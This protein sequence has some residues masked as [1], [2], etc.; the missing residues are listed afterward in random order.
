ML[1]T[2]VSDPPGSDGWVYEVKWDGYRA[3]AY[4]NKTNV[5]IRSRNNLEFNKKFYPIRDALKEVS[6]QAILDGEIIVLDEEGRSHFESLQNWRSE[7]DGQ[8]IYYVFDLLWANGHSLMH[9]P[10]TERREQLQSIF[11]DHPL[12]R[13]SEL[14]DTNGNEFLEVAKKM[15]MEGIMAKRTD[16]EYTPSARTKEWLKIKTGLRQEVVIGGFT[17]N[18]GTSKIF[19]ALLVGV[20]EKGK[21]RYTGK[22]G[23]GFSIRLQQEMMKQFKP[24]ISKENPFDT[25]PDINKPSRFRPDP[26]DAKATWLKPKL[27]CEVSFTEMTRDGMMRHPSFE[28]MREDK[29]AMQGKEE[30]PSKIKTEKKSPELNG[31]KI[32]KKAAAGGRKT[33]V[34][35][36]DKQQVR[37]VDGRELKFT[38]LDKIYWPKEKITKGDMINYY[39]K[40]AP[41]MLPYMKDRPQSL[42]RY[43]NGINGES[44]YQKNIAGKMP[45]WIKTHDYENKTT[46]GNKKFLVCADEATLIYM[47]NLGC[48]EMNPWHSRIQAPDN[49]DWSVIDLDPDK[50]TFEQ[51]I[52]AAQIVQ[53][54]LKSAGIP[55]YPK[56]SGSTGMHI[57]IPLGA[58]YSYEQS[59]VLAQVIVSL[60][61]REIPGYTTLERSPSK[62]KGKMYLDFLQNRSIQTIAAPYSLRPRP[63]ATV[64][65]PLH[66]D[67]VKPGLKP[68]D[69]TIYNSIDRIKETNDLFKPV[70]GKGIQLEAV[71]KKL[72]KL[73]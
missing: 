73:L 27:V 24:L 53:Q 35:P 67:E 52:E 37:I 55:S 1:A 13:I 60:V 22:V 39:Y 68:T 42:N 57:Y 72:E 2:L 30:K 71:L 38:N 51:V 43:P 66:W 34:N 7:A 49:P 20:Y 23:T 63:G 61:H 46:E 9:L 3:L 59:K 65:M 4:C 50:N 69:F 19:S 40:V 18:E 62:R 14:F 41:Y 12:I 21:L 64:S 33:L 8:L 31:K 44:F 26:P 15:Q 36:T 56:T 6:M 11:P 28:G 45:G 10:L 47:A 70:L 5:D 32:L 54:V 58:K 17:K 25:L 48:I 16:S 29:K